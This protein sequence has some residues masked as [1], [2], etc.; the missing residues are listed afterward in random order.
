A[1]LLVP[2]I[3]LSGQIGER[4]RDRFGER[5]IVLHSALD[6]RE[7]Y[8]N[9]Q[10][11]RGG[12]P[13]VVVGPRS[14]LFA[15]L[16]NVGLIVRHEEHES[17]YKQDSAPRY[18]ARAVAAWLADSHDALLVLGS[19]TPDVERYQRTDGPNWRRLELRER[20]GQRVLDGACEISAA[21]IPLPKT[22]IVDMRAELRAG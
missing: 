10:R 22:R 13:L 14:A 15:P 20:V 4:V 16:P 2:E 11:A 8:D 3:A 7:R 1:I 21:P 17:A 18:H 9:R 5:S 12:E 6:D 19:A